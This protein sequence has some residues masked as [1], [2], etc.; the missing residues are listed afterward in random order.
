MN[1]GTKMQ[2]NTRAKV[3][4]E[5][6]NHAIEQLN[7]EGVRPTIRAV[8]ERLGAGS[9]NRIQPILAAWH[10][11]NKPAEAAQATLDDNDAQVFADILA[12]TRS[13]A[14]AAKLEEITE[15]KGQ[16]DEITQ[17]GQQLEDDN[18][19]LEAENTQLDEQKSKA[20]T[21]ADARE[22]RIEQLEAEQTRLQTQGQEL[23]Q[24]LAT[25][26]A[27]LAMQQQQSQQQQ[28]QIEQQAAALTEAQQQTN[29]AQQAAAVSEAKQQAAVE[30]AVAAQKRIAKLEQQ[31]E[32]AQQSASAKVDALQKR[33][34][35]TQL[36]RTLD[37]QSHI[38]QLAQ[39]DEQLHVEH[40][41][42]K[43]LMNQIDELTDKLTALKKPNLPKK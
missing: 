22:Q 18:E 2:A 24:Q 23:T 10:D 1:K 40:E 3:T 32:Q 34:D 11:S 17:A 27:R 25:T 30:T 9:P 37:A 12:R 33:I 20:V 39:R 21:L 4:N 41:K 19:R 31:L 13:K 42:N 5:Q 14:V 35:E 16:L 6:I 38:K 36:Q 7:S 26:Q 28:L 15:L 29:A 43:Q 8:R